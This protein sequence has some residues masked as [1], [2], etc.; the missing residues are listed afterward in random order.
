VKADE[1]RARVFPAAN[2][3]LNR[4]AVT[5]RL[6]DAVRELR[7]LGTTVEELEGLVRRVV[8]E[9]DR[10]VDQQR[11]AALNARKEES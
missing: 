1:L 3:G 11:L 8:A 6:V 10:I 2:K 4:S 9:H 7:A 5:R